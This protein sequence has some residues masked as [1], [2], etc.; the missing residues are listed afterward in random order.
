MTNRPA[1][2]KRTGGGVEKGL[3]LAIAGALVAMAALFPLARLLDDQTDR[4]RPMYRD[5]LTMAWLQYDHLRQGGGV[6]PVQLS[7]GESTTVDGQSFTTSPGVTVRVKASDGGYCVKGWDQF[8]DATAWKC[9]DGETRPSPLGA[10]TYL[11]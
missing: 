1:A 2:R 7:G 3:V 6:E 4:Q 10:L 9:G 11:D 5:V 8:G